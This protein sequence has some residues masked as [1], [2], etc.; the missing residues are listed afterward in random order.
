M[1][2]YNELYGIPEFPKY[3]VIPPPDLIGGSHHKE[4]RILYRDSWVK[5]EDDIAG[6]S[7]FSFFWFLPKGLF[8]LYLLQIPK[9]LAIIL[10]SFKKAQ[11][12]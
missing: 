8:Y 10:G 2:H 9:N 7:R 11:N 6:K 3:G 5:P 4:S 1:L 12:E